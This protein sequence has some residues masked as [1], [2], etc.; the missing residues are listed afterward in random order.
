MQT[1]TEAYQVKKIKPAF[2]RAQLGLKQQ[3]LAD[4]AGTSQRVISTSEN[5]VP[6]RL[7][8]AFAILE[9]LNKKRAEKNLEPLEFEDVEWT[10]R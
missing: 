9:A 8:T 1:T 10:I 5:G 2:A 6:I 3:E 4:L 7:L